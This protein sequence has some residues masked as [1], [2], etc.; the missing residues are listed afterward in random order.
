MTFVG[1]EFAEQ[2][3]D[4]QDDNQE[5]KAT[6]AVITCSIKRTPANSGKS[7]QQCDDQEDRALFQ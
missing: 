3:Q 2:D 6:P 5:A 4:Q 7:A 1:S